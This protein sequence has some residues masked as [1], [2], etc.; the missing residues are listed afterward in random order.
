MNECTLPA[1]SHRGSPR[2][3]SPAARPRCRYV[4]RT[5]PLSIPRIKKM[6]LG[7]L[8]LLK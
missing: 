4:Q 6:V 1:R 3:T 8:V 7:C 5:R 2:G